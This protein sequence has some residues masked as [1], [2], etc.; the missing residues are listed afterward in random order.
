M[1]TQSYFWLAGPVE[2][3]QKHN[4]D[5]QLTNSRGEQPRSSANWAFLLQ[6]SK[7]KKQLN[8]KQR[9][10]INNMFSMKM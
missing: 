9:K 7:V 2:L 4:T 1:V 3:A 5:M 6:I 10:K 8:G